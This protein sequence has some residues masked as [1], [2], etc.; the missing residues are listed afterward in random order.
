[1]RLFSNILSLVFCLFSSAWLTTDAGTLTLKY[2][3]IG[4]I[5]TRTGDFKVYNL[6]NT[7]Q[8]RSINGSETK[9]L[10]ITVLTR[11]GSRQPLNKYNGF[12]INPEDP[13]LTTIGQLQMRQQGLDLASTY[14]KNST[15]VFVTTSDNFN[16]TN[17]FYI[18]GPL[19]AVYTFAES[20][21]FRRTL[22]SATNFLLGFFNYDP[23]PM[24]P[25]R[26][27]RREDDY[28]LRAWDYCS[29]FY[30]AQ[31]I[32]TSSDG[33]INKSIEVQPFLDEIQTVLL[34][35]TT[36]PYYS[37]PLWLGSNGANQLTLKNIW[38]LYDAMTVSEVENVN[39]TGIDYVGK[40]TPNQKQK[41]TDLATFFELQRHSISTSI[42]SLHLLWDVVEWAKSFSKPM[43]TIENSTKENVYRNK[44]NLYSGHY[45][46]MMSLFNNLFMLIQNNE[47]IYK[48]Q[49]NILNRIPDYASALVFELH[50]GQ[51]Q[52]FLGSYDMTNAFIKIKF[53]NGLDGGISNAANN[54]DTNNS[55]T[56]IADS[57][58]YHNLFSPLCSVIVE[59]SDP[60]KNGYACSVRD[61]ENY[62]VQAINNFKIGQEQSSF[63]SPYNE[64]SPFT[65]STSTARRRLAT[66][67][68]LL[69]QLPSTTITDRI[70]MWKYMCT[71][72]ND[73]MDT[74]QKPETGFSYRTQYNVALAVMIPIIVLLTI[75]AVVLGV[76]LYMS[77][78]TKAERADTIKLEDLPSPIRSPPPEPSDIVIST[79]V[80]DYYPHNT[81]FV[82]FNQL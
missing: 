56:Q 63:E 77:R 46:T 33:Y 5:T 36:G 41:I 38:N 67:V 43:T 29:K 51:Y 64:D 32:W 6:K 65:V 37:P 25:I 17:K 62:I 75:V 81:D 18:S 28:T 61:L 58:L 23:F 53:R 4:Y 50:G 21:Y 55:N 44:F 10:G 42:L 82:D 60:L 72:F 66:S 12:E 14:L 20:S 8:L 39:L 79:D 31:T 78:N 16:N 54:T 71:G 15:N 22:S 19:K 9:L 68:D 80:V 26:T 52:P 11:H 27:P 73:T 74:P 35:N 40:L 24:V 48:D 7:E 2:G 70:A 76:L 49:L 30:T 57:P 34:G 69:N 13:L 1:M 47:T 45:P 59:G 3:P